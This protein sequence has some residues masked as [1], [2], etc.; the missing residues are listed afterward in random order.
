VVSTTNGTR[1]VQDEVDTMTN[2]T[3]ASRWTLVNDATEVRRFDV[4]VT[5]SSLVDATGND[6]SADLLADRGAF[7]VVY[8][9]DTG[10]SK[11]FVYRV[12]GDVAVRVVSSDGYV[13]ER[14]SVDW[15]TGNVTVDLV[16]A[17]IGGRNA[18]ALRDFANLSTPYD[19]S[20]HRGAN[21]TGVYDFVVDRPA[22]DGDV[23]PPGSVLPGP[24]GYRFLYSV[25]VT[26]RYVSQELTYETTVDVP[27]GVGP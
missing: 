8:E 5:P 13:S 10:W 20:F 4:T 19:V 12:N 26:F 25:S 27:G 6:S 14:Y 21:A 23:A 3:G 18:P 24:R 16:N 17:T 9:T 7:A 15:T 22:I 2:R 1:L 11:V